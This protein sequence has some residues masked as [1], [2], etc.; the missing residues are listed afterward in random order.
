[1]FTGYSNLIGDRLIHTRKILYEPETAILAVED[2]VEGKG[3][4]LSES[5][6]HVHLAVKIIESCSDLFLHKEEIKIKLTIK[7]ARFRI[8]DGVYF[9]QFGE[10]TGSKVIVLFSEKIPVQMNYSFKIIN[11]G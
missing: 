3:R 1:L 10:K 9:P 4:H 2:L 8:D 7:D 6:I 5:F 11:N